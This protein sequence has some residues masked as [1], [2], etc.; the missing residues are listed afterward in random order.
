LTLLLLTLYIIV[1]AL[2]TAAYSAR[3]ASHGSLKI[4]PGALVFHR[5]MILNIP[6]IADLELLRQ[7]RQA[8]IDDIS[9]DYQP[10]DEIQ[11]LAYKPGKLDPRANAPFRIVR[12]H[13][14][15]TVTIQR[16]PLVTERSNI[17]RLRP[18]KR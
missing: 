13:T 7:R 12:I 1:T 6:I 9:H 18:Y 2:Q 4:T 15:G 5:D 8:L 16:T 10:N 14:N 3:E 17:R 11:I